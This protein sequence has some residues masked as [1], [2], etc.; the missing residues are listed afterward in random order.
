MVETELLRLFESTFISR[1]NHGKGF[2]EGNLM[3]MQNVIITYV[4]GLPMCDLD[5]DLNNYHNDMKNAEANEPEPLF[6]DQG[7]RHYADIMDDVDYQWHPIDNG[8][9]NWDVLNK[10]RPCLTKTPHVYGINEG[11]S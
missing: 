3:E 1:S 5:V 8:A 9:F 2:F 11:E 6:V 7:W 4:G 10:I